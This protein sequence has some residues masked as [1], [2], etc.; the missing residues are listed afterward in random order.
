MEEAEPALSALPAADG[1]WTIRPKTSEPDQ[2]R[3]QPPG[4]KAADIVEPRFIHDRHLG[5]M[6]ADQDQGRSK[7]WLALGLAGAVYVMGIAGLWSI[8]RTF[9]EMTNLPLTPARSIEPNAPSREPTDL[10]D[11]ELIEATP[12]TSG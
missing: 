4:L 11:A 10:Q 3:A 8:Y 1:H 7:R 6:V 9:D 2:G 12:L 5:A